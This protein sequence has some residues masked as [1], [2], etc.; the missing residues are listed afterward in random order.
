MAHPV[1]ACCQCD[2]KIGYVLFEVYDESLREAIKNLV[3]DQVWGRLVRLRDVGSSIRIPAGRFSRIWPVEA[4][5]VRC[6]RCSGQDA[7]R[8][9]KRG[10]K[11]EVVSII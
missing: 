10:D 7:P 4:K 5:G 1:I 6:F 3:N 11:L 8:D 9:W 2:K